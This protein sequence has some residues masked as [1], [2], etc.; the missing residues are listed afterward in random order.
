MVV[1][2]PDDEVLGCGGAIARHIKDG[3]EVVLLVLTDG[4]SAR[5]D[6]FGASNVRRLEL[7]ESSQ[8]LGISSYFQLNMPDNR[9]DTISTLEVIQAIAPIF[10]RVNPHI[11]YTHFLY[12]LNQDHSVVARAIRILTRP[13]S[14]VTLEMVLMMEVPSSTE[15]AFGEQCQF[16]PNHFVA[17]SKHQIDV[18]LKA[19]SRYTS[20]LRLAPHPRRIEH[21]LVVAQ[22]R[23][24]QSGYEYAEAFMV[25]RSIF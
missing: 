2:H 20:E 22:Q 19:L 9:L 12:D 4:V 1:A 24:A 16:S 6:N 25:L 13:I 8:V 3:C 23:G 15:W 17:L 7:Q 18:K 14:P 11:V 10:S 21:A 5:G